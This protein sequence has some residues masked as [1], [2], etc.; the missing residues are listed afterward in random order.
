MFADW[1]K[2]IWTFE[3]VSYTKDSYWK[4]VK[5]FISL[6]AWIKCR[7]WKWSSKISSDDSKEEQFV[8]TYKLYAETKYNWA[9]NWD[10]VIIDWTNYII[11]WKQIAK[12]WASN[13]I[14][15]NLTQDV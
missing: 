1:L 2:D 14:I 3:T 13:H 5:G 8:V 7:L 9:N 4:E 10:R 12:W 15:Y 11:Y 6:Y